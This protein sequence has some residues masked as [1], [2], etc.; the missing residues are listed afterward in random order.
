M[1]HHFHRSTG[2]LGPVDGLDVIRAY[3]N[4]IEPQFGSAGLLRWNGRMGKSGLECADGFTVSVVAGP[5]GY[6]CWPRPGWPMA[7]NVDDELRTVEVPRSYRGP[8][9]AFE[10]GYPSQR[11]EPWERWQLHASDPDDWAFIYGYVPYGMVRALV[12]LHGG[13]VRMLHDATVS[14]PRTR[15]TKLARP[16]DLADAGMGPCEGDVEPY[17]PTFGYGGEKMAFYCR[18]H[19]QI[20]EDM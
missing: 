8:F 11:P 4:R 6:Y 12:N 3:G 18:R 7:V 13:L 5:F 17:T 20:I 15:H 9:A 14:R 19:G 1:G 2:P 10:V 16:C